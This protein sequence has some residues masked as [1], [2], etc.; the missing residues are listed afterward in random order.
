MGGG[1]RTRA[2]RVGIIPVGQRYFIGGLW[3]IPVGTCN[4]G[5]LAANPT[6]VTQSDIGDK[7][8][9]QLCSVQLRRGARGLAE[10]VRHRAGATTGEK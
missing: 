3:D 7:R 10:T 4:R 8:A 1:G 9:L 5:S 2:A 6:G